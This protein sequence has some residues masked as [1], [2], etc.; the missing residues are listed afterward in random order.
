ML[1]FDRLSNRICRSRFTTCSVWY[2]FP[3]VVLAQFVTWRR[4]AGP[5]T[6]IINATVSSTPMASARPTAIRRHSHQGRLSFTSYIS[7]RVS[8]S[9]AVADE[10]DH[11]AK[12]SAN[13]ALPLMTV[14]GTSGGR[15]SFQSVK[16]Q[17]PDR[18]TVCSHSERDATAN[19]ELILY[20]LC[21]LRWSKSHLLP[22]PLCVR[23]EV[24]HIE[25]ENDQ[26][27]D[28][29]SVQ[30]SGNADFRRET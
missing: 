6:T 19:V 30:E 23:R 15:G 25:R 13:Q 24:R 28:D 29:A 5:Y 4:I 22:T 9:P 3:R 17:R 1:A 20:I 11:S 21:H 7:L 2:F 12:S 18:D 26:P 16:L 14:C 27:E 8:I 10:E